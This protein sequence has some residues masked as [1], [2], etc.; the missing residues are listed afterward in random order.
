MSARLTSKFTVDALIRRIEHDGGN[1]AVLARGDA[2]NGNILLL[3][4]E[5]GRHSAVMERLLDSDGLYGWQRVAQ[6]SGAEVGYVERRLA[7]D[8]DLW[9]LEL[10]T[11]NAERFA[12]EMI[13]GD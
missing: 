5:K 11:P 12:A 9:V 13:A 4:V 10:D 7:R 6:G 3:I 2:E 1:A 8:P